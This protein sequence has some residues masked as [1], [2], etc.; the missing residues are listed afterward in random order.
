MRRR[1][2]LA[3]IALGCAT[4]TPKPPPAIVHTDWTAQHE[5]V[6]SLAPPDLLGGLS[7][8]SAEH[9]IG[10][11]ASLRGL[12]A[13]GKA[14]KRMVDRWGAKLQEGLGF[15]PLDRAAWQSHGVALDGP[16]AFF[17]LR[18][19]RGIWVLK[20]TDEELVKRSFAARF[21]CTRV[22]A[23]LACGD[24]EV[25]PAPNAGASIW[26][27]VQK[28]VPA[29]HLASELLLFVPLETYFSEEGGRV[30]FLRTFSSS[31]AVSAAVDVADDRI[32]LALG[33]QNPDT[34]RLKKYLTAEPDVKSLLGSLA[35]GRSML[36]FSFSPHELWG[37]ARAEVPA[38]TLA[39]ASGGF[40]LATGLDLEKDIVDNLT[41]E[42]VAGYYDQGGLVEMF[43]TRDDAQQL[44]RLAPVER[45]DAEMWLRASGDSRDLS[46]ALQDRTQ[47]FDCSSGLCLGRTG[48]GHWIA[49]AVEKDLSADG[50]GYA[51]V[52]ILPET[53]APSACG[54]AKLIVDREML[55][56]E[57]AISIW[58]DGK[59]LRW[60]SVKRERGRRLWAPAAEN[61]E[62]ME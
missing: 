6:W 53:I 41:G 20:A 18:G 46:K 36:R 4:C 19:E 5:R 60:T 32:H 3:L 16:M 52:L 61:D 45:F 25:S 51:D 15:D 28:E 22:G 58:F 27:R 47:G 12:V 14:G 35:G 57:G 48:A 59:G 39:Q 43:G 54:T 44:I 24:A 49:V 42:I 11:L 37:L 56:R 40:Q 38:K 10:K 7:A 30:P 33:Y 26:G 9:M 29:D 50:C 34:A 21:T 55:A 13:S 62:K 1:T 17:V 8:G 23:L 2:T 31:R